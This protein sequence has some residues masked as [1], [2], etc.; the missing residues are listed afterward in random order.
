M[1]TQANFKLTSSG[2]A[3]SE[4]AAS[5]RSNSRYSNFIQ[6]LEYV[7]P[8]LC[9]VLGPEA[10]DTH[11]NTG[12]SLCTSG[13]LSVWGWPNTGTGC[14]EM[15]WSLHP[16][17]YSKAAWTWSWAAISG[18]PCLSRGVGGPLPTEPFCDSVF[19]CFAAWDHFF[20]LQLPCKSQFRLVPT[21]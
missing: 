1:Q 11:W 20:L 7:L 18:W 15:L 12:G 9:P 19:L 8:I 4:E 3:R 5:Q 16:W 10:M 13:T 21:S 6:L 17:R 14:P 2:T